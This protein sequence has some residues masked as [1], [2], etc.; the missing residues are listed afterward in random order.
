TKGISQ[1]II[2]IDNFT[3]KGILSKYHIS[4]F[5]KRDGI[6][7][8]YGTTSSVKSY[9]Y[10]FEKLKNWMIDILNTQED[11]GPLEELTQ[12]MKFAAKDAKGIV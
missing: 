9:S 2:P 6:V 4:S 8:D 3:E 10:F 11:C 12:F 7:Y 5:I 1:D